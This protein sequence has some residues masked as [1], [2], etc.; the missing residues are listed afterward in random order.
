MMMMIM[1]MVMLM[2]LLL[3]LLMMMMMMMM[4]IPTC[5]AAGRLSSVRGLHTRSAAGYSTHKV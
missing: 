2:L 3:L 4:M 1:I 5:P